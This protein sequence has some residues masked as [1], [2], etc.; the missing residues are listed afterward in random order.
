MQGRSAFFFVHDVLNLVHYIHCIVRYFSV[1]YSYTVHY[2]VYYIHYT[3]HYN[4]HYF[5]DSAHNVTLSK[6]YHTLHVP[7]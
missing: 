7:V 6:H 2:T 3:V 4:A 1:L 5:I